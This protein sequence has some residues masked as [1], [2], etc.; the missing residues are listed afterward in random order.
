MITL[1]GPW[2][3]TL[4]A[5]GPELSRGLR[6]H[7]CT[8]LTSDIAVECKLLNKTSQPSSGLKI[9]AQT[10]FDR[11]NRQVTNKI[12]PSLSQ[13]TSAGAGGQGAGGSLS[14]LFFPIA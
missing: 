9:A 11:K 7:Q 5:T 12:C 13:K 3:S 14:D 1:H 10:K 4:W 2:H 6:D 8:T